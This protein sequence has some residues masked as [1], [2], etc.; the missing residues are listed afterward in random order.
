LPGYFYWSG[1]KAFFELQGEISWLA[2]LDYLAYALLS[3]GDP[4]EAYMRKH[5]E[6][7]PAEDLPKSKEG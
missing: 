2:A 7:L 4:K 6:E 1:P 5:Y 3:L